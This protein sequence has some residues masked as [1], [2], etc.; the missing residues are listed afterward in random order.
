MAKLT[1]LLI[2]LVLNTY[3]IRVTTIILLL[4]YSVGKIE[5]QLAVYNFTINPMQINTR[6]E[7]LNYYSIN[8]QKLIK[9]SKGAQSLHNLHQK[10]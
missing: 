7:T 8:L 2:E 6:R 4:V 5:I 3:T 10:I 1:S 9:T